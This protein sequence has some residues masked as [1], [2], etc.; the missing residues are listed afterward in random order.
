MIKLI[1]KSM[2]DTK[3]NNFSKYKW[4]VIVPTFNNARTLEQVLSK[5]LTI[6]ENI[7]IIN[8]GSNDNTSDILKKF[9]NKIDIITHSKNFG[10]GKALKNGF[11][12]A[13]NN[14]FDYAITI[15]SDGQHYPEDIPLLLNKT[16]EYPDALVI[17]ARNMS[18]NDVPR[19]SSFGNKFS[20]FWF[21]FETGIH[22]SDTQTGF[23]L[24]PLNKLKEIK[25]IT[26][27]FEFEIEVLVRMAWK[28]TIIKEVPIKVKYDKTERISHFRPFLDFARI[29]V[30][31]TTLV[32]IALLYQIPLRF[33]F[34]LFGKEKVKT[35]IKKFFS[36]EGSP[37]HKSLSV[38]FGVFMGIIPIWGFQMLVATLLAYTLKLNKVIVLIASNISIP[39]LIPFIIFGSYYMGQFFLGGEDLIFSLDI[40]LNTI[41]SMLKQYILG[42]F[43]LA[44][45]VGIIFFFCTYFTLSLLYKS[46]K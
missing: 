11:K 45:F 15:D 27:K 32:I 33:I 41:Q 13:I 25:L 22:L 8:D 29:S 36:Q 19:K 39:P 14:G 4:C 26:N 17:G 37:L 9:T 10:K 2:Q 46:K 35:I 31:N 1:L 16:E 21:W 40:D 24:Y 28:D 20:N 18:Q 6:T 44:I 12:H 38:G 30:L 43:L 7:I 34:K 3:Q 23:R 5:I 42:S